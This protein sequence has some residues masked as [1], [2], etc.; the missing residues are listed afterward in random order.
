MPCVSDISLIL[1]LLERRANSLR[2]H[3]KQALKI[4]LRHKNLNLLDL[5]NKLPNLKQLNI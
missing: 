4:T 5:V 3:T 2:E 1:S